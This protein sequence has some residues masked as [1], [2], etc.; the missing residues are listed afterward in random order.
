MRQTG[1][2]HVNGGVILDGDCGCAVGDEWRCEDEV[3]VWSGQ[4][5]ERGAIFVEL[6]YYGFTNN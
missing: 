2:V 5:E 6:H 3:G 1:E 4:C